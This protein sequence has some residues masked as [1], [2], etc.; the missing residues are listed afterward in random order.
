MSLSLKKSILVSAALLVA[1]S[2]MA[3]SYD[4]VGVSYNNDCYRYSNNYYKNDKSSTKANGI[5][6]NYVHGFGLHKRLPMFLEVGGSLN[7]NYKDDVRSYESN[8]ITIDHEFQFH[9]IYLTIPVNFAWKF[10]FAK[11]F[12]ITPYTGIDFKLNCLVRE[13]QTKSVDGITY[14]KYWVDWLTRDKK[15]GPAS[16]WSVFQMGWHIGSTFG[17]RQFSL[18][19]QYEID[20]IPAYYQPYIYVDHKEVER[21][22]TSGFKLTLGYNF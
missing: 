14:S 11:D 1:T 12:Y 8:E 4:R 7:Y 19:V 13:R 6:L 20:F 10:D 16:H 18:G 21:F 22:D 9:N 17:W 2:A 15:K 3:E 5:G